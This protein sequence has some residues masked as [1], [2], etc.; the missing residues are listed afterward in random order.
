MD[1]YIV[2]L[3]NKLDDNS[4]DRQLAMDWLYIDR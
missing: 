4:V 1:E 2:D 3:K